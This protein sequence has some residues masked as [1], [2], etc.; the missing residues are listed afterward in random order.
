MYFLSQVRRIV[1]FLTAR[2]KLLTKDS[3]LTNNKDS[4][5]TN[6]LGRDSKDSS[7]TKQQ[8]IKFLLSGTSILMSGTVVY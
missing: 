4:R 2:I 3:R 8:V 6:N 5:L 1:D 7:L